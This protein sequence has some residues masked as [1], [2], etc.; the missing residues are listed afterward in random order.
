MRA[1]LLMKKAYVIEGT[2]QT[3]SYGLLSTN[4]KA[5]ICVGSRTITDIQGW[6]LTTMASII[7]R[8]KNECI[9]IDLYKGK[10]DFRFNLEEDEQV[11]E[12]QRETIIKWTVDKTLQYIKI[13]DY[14]RDNLKFKV[15]EVLS[16]AGSLPDILRLQ[17][18]LNLTGNS[19]EDTDHYEYCNV[20]D[21]MTPYF[22]GSVLYDKT[23]TVPE[24]A[25]WGGDGAV[26]GGKVVDYGMRNEKEAGKLVVL[27]ERADHSIHNVG[28]TVLVR[29]GLAK[30]CIVKSEDE[31]VFEKIGPGGAK[32]YII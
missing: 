19:F 7:L 18:S 24:R 29:V 1:D 3:I 14:G 27:L 22:N 21:V 9:M 8:T 10:V 26:Y 13:M 28:D 25:Y 17:S 15:L 31:I 16:Q 5:A 4:N 23:H 2:E 32:T 30:I 11:R 12:S 6:Y 20:L